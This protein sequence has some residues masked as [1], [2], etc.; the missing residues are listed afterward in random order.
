MNVSLSGDRRLMREDRLIIIALILFALF[1]RIVTLMM[2]HT[3]VDERDYWYSAKAIAVGLPYPELTH[4][5]VRFAVILPTA[6]AQVLLGSHPDV[7]YV[8]PV[9]NCMIQAALAYAIGL[10]LKGRLTGFLAA[11]GLVFFPYMIREASQVRPEIFSITYVLAAI[12]CFLSY[13]EKTEKRGRFLI[14]AA[15]W[16]FV[17]YEANITNLFFVPGFIVVIIAMKRPARDLFSFC[18]ILFG[19]FV[20]ETGAYALLTDYKFGQLQVIAKNHLDGNPALKAMRFQDLFLRYARPY[21]QIYWQVPFVAF[22]AAAF[23]FLRRKGDVAIKALAAIALSFFLF[24]TF[25]IKSIHP[26]TPAEPF[27]NR[28]FSAVLGPLFLVLAAAVQDLASCLAPGGFAHRKEGRAEAGRYVALLVGLA[29]FISAAFSSPFLPRKFREYA[30]SMIS[31][32]EHPLVLNEEY[33]REINAAYEAGLPVVAV[34]SLGGMNA[35]ETC[36]SYFLSLLNYTQGEPPH[37]ISRTLNGNECLILAKPEADY[38]SSPVF[39]AVVRQP[40]RIS[41]IASSDIGGLCDDAFPKR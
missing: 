13:L 2:I 28:Y 5:T 19:L 35:L 14:G 40:F 36:R 27:I 11:M 32:N 18:G 38:S 8:I 16:M 10:R 26:I 24:V 31:F 15:L 22:A 25:A 1:F 6:V 17:A 9:L 4:R 33:R 39:L 30:H 7:Y 20:L 12:W 21:L 23:Y 29:I 34:D 41:R 3:G 37:F